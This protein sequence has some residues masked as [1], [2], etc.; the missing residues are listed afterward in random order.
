M[1][2]APA[3]FTARGLFRWPTTAFSAAAP[4]P[5]RFRPIYRHNR[6]IA[7]RLPELAAAPAATMKTERRSRLTMRRRA[8]V[9]VVVVFLP[10]EFKKKSHVAFA[11]HRPRPRVVGPRMMAGATPLLRRLGDEEAA[12]G[13]NSGGRDRG[14]NGLHVQWP[15]HALGAEPQRLA[16]RQRRRRRWRRRLSTMR[17]RLLR[18][19][20]DQQ[21]LCAG[22]DEQLLPAGGNQLCHGRRGSG[23][24]RPGVGRHLRSVTTTV[25]SCDSL[26]ETRRCSTRRRVF[27]R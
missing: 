17:P 12:D 21:L 15:A 10:L 24:C 19:S 20:H 1:C 13:Y 6:P 25:R 7:Q 2:K 23:R 3:G 11:H 4:A 18:T 26:P 9:L 5:R 8:A 16:M 14:I 27:M 22:R